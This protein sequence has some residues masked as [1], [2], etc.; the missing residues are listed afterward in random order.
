MAVPHSG[1]WWFHG[2]DGVAGSIPAGGSTPILTSRNASQ[3]CVQDRCT[4]NA[5]HLLVGD[6]LD[7]A[8]TG[9]RALPLSHASGHQVF[10]RDC[11]PWV[12]SSYHRLTSLFS[13][14]PHLSI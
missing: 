9:W 11:L 13:A 14:R 1:S 2:K 5:G 3:L 8:H 4:G 10:E 6:E 12:V 7:G